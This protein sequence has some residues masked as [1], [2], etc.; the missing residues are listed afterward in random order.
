MKFCSTLALVKVNTSDGVAPVPVCETPFTDTDQRPAV[1]GRSARDVMV[2]F[3]NTKLTVCATTVLPW[4]VVV[5]LTTNVP[6]EGVAVQPEDSHEVAVR[7]VLDEERQ[8]RGRRALRLANNCRRPD[9]SWNQTRFGED[10]R[11]SK[12][13]RRRVDNYL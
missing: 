6:D 5:P 10:N 3:R 11:V 13:K 9:G 8:C 1:T 2:Y 7:P 12:P 4:L